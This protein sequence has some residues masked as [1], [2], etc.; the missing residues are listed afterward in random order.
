MLGILKLRWLFQL[1]PRTYRYLV[2]G[3]VPF[4][5][6]WLPFIGIAFFFTPIARIMNAFPLV[7]L[8]DEF[9]ITLI[10]MAIFTWAAAKYLKHLA[11]KLNNEAG[12]TSKTPLNTIEGEY[13]VV[14]LKTF[15]LRHH[16]AEKATAKLIA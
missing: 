10:G 11:D 6:K 16:K 14:T 12:S 13:E 5:Y 1:L 2:D 8:L 4:Y 3:R 9:T 15:P 7:S